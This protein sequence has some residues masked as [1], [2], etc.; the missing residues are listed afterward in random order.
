[1]LN[2]YAVLDG[3]NVFHGWQT[4]L[5]GVGLTSTDPNHLDYYNGV[6]VK[7]YSPM[8]NAIRAEGQIGG[9]SAE[10]AATS[11]GSFAVSGLVH[12][13]LGIGVSAGNDAD[14]DGRSEALRPVALTA[15][16]VKVDPADP[17]NR[18][19]TDFSMAIHAWAPGF[20]SIGIRV[21]GGSGP[22]G[23]AGEFT[24]SVGGAIL[25]GYGT[26][27]SSSG[28]FGFFEIAGTGDATFG[29][30]LS[31]ANVLPHGTDFAESM[32]VAGAKSEY[33]PGDLMAIDA[34]GDRRLVKATAEYSTSVA[35]IH[36]T[37]PGVLASP[38]AAGDPRLADDVPLAMVGIVPCKV[39]AANGA[40]ARGDLLVASSLPGHAMKGTD[41][42]RMLGAVVGKALQPLPSG[43]GVI[44][45][46][47]TLQ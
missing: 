45:V 34:A 32:D 28:R 43:T 39:T 29:G 24:N 21:E 5:G 14:G 7:N 38:Y 30:S 16:S 4:I 20:N 25:R 26:C 2:G 41:R 13:P 1:M 42:T 27:C 35:G 9:I 46:L 40:I 15:A 3:G 44:L 10:A 17:D 19:G 37:K 22:R 47:V 6:T 36:A 11:G 23:A 12:S 33:E 18:L 8:G 31:A